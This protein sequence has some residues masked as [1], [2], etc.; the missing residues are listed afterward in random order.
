[1]KKGLTLLLAVVMAFSL[2]AC[3]AQPAA[4]DSTAPA[5]TAASAAPAEGSNLEK[6][7]AID[8]SKVMST[9]NQPLMKELA[10][11]EFPTRPENV[12]ALGEDDAGKYYDMEYAGWDTVKSTNLPK[13]PADG[14][15]GKHVIVI[16]HGDHPWTTAYSNGIK[17]ACEAYGMTMDI[18]SPNWDVNVQNQMIDQAINAQPDAIALIPINTE[19]AA[20][21]FRKIT[22]AG[23]PAFGSNLLTTSDAMSYMIAWTGPDDW[24]Q[25]R[26]LAR[27]MADDMGKKGGVAYLTHNPG[28][29]AYFARMY[30][31]RTEL[32]TYAPDI[33][34]LDFQSPGFDAPKCK[35]VV[36]DWITR[37][38][39]DLTAIYCADDSAQATG[40]VDACKEAGREDILIYAAGNS[41]A[42]QDMVKAGDME[43]INYQSAEG[44]AGA[45]VMTMANW[46]NGKEVPPMGYLVP[47]MITKDN[48]DSFYPCQW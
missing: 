37:F 4:A 6:S 31:P 42:G 24:A 8:V 32:T 20:Q 12:D 10:F 41:K 2:V 1:M 15:I 48:V 21:Q 22:E 45:V 29:S 33:K 35:Q 14:S 34:T 39:D 47:A 25:M 13:S 44:D 5:S 43:A 40:A 18:W 17:K 27:T 38:G 28:G 36:S 3:S 16:V 26:T 23:I 46:F 7:L 9:D 19:S 11:K 30:G